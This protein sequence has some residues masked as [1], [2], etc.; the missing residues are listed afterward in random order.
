[1]SIRYRPTYGRFHLPPPIHPRETTA[2]FSIY[3]SKVADH[4]GDS[5]S[6][7]K[8][9]ALIVG[10]GFTENSGYPADKNG[11]ILESDYEGRELREIAFDQNLKIGR[12]DAF[13]YFGDGFFY[14]LDSPGHAI[15]HMCGL[16]RVT[17]SLSFFILMG[18]DICHHVGQFRPSSQLPL[19]S[20]ISPSPFDRHSS[21]ACPV[22][23][24]EHLL[25]DNDRKKPFYNVARPGNGMSVAYDA[26]VA[27]ASI[28]KLQETDPFDEVLVVIAHDNSLLSVADFFPK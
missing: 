4:T 15:G 20:I 24:F 11:R 8:S 22:E 16:A 10:P 21:I 6:F 3:D 2:G 7:K 28:S 5:S 26:D 9:T 23:V 25:P 14:L 27:D 12:F 13:D 19:P 17:S 18:G 1:M